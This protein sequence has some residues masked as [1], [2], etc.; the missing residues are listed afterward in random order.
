[1]EFHCAIKPDDSLAYL[2]LCLGM[3]QE[4]SVGQ[5]SEEILYSVSR[6]NILTRLQDQNSQ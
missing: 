4:V 6:I 3:L 1:M 2:T 5:Y